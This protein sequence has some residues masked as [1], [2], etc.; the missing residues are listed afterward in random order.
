VFV[1]VSYFEE[2]LQKLLAEKKKLKVLI[3][4]GVSIN[5][6]DASGE[7]MLRENYKRLRD[8]GVQIL[9]TRIKSHIMEIFRRSHFFDDV[10]QT[11]FH[12]QPADVFAHAW[13]IVEEANTEQDLEAE[14]EKAR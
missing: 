7:E 6:L 11:S 4:D 14:S 1:N 13:R 9:F 8:A 10:D 12:R 2:Q 3:I 5:D